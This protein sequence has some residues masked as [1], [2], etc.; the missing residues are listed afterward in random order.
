MIGWGERYR[1]KYSLYF[2]G[3][4]S[5]YTDYLHFVKKSRSHYN[6]YSAGLKQTVSKRLLVYQ[7]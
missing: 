5:V 6:V 2:Y 1:I 3:V 7:K 4:L